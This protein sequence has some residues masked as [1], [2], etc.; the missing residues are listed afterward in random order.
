MWFGHPCRSASEKLEESF[1]VERNLIRSV[2]HLVSVTDT[3][4]ICM[5]SLQLGKIASDL[6]EGFRW[7]S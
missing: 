5:L 1:S 4:L 6:A 3:F 7:Q 2:G